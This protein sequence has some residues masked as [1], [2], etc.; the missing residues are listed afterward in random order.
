MEMRVAFT[1]SPYGHVSVTLRP[2]T[3]AENTGGEG[4]VHRGR[5]APDAAEDPVFDREDRLGGSLPGADDR[6]FFDPDDPFGGSFPGADDP[7]SDAVLRVAA[8]LLEPPAPITATV[9]RTASDRV[10]LLMCAS[11]CVC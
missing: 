10:V 4:P 11:P 6:R 2:G 7:A 3:P 9:A 5:R 8:R 1:A